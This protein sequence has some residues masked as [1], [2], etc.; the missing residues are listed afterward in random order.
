MKKILT[1]SFF[2][3][4]TL[5]VARELLG[6]YLVQDYRG[7]RLAVMVAEVEAY[8]GPL[9]RASHAYRGITPR[10]KIMFGPA[11]NFYV[12]FTY[13]MHWMVNVVTGP[14]GYPSAILLRAG[15]YKDT[16]TGKLI[17]IKGPALL[18]R[19]LEIDKTQNGKPASRAT[20]LWF[21]DCGMIIRSRDVIAQKRIGV[22]Y[23]GRIWKNKPYNFRFNLTSLEKHGKN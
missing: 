6:K 2:D 14:T 13:G 20:G 23:A 22:D 8:D 1:R 12:Y 15:V 7:K 16:R 18:T 9:D 3:R 5:L 4:P 21:E 10:T 11:G 17:P 19:Y